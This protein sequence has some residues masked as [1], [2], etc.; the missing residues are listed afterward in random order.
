MTACQLADLNPCGFNL[1]SMLKGKGHVNDPHSLEEVKQNI[2]QEISF[3]P[4]QELHHVSRN[5]FF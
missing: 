2:Q 1:C 4:R 3:I 5:N